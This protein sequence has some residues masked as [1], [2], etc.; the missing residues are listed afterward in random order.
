MPCVARVENARIR[1]LSIQHIFVKYEEFREYYNLHN[2]HYLLLL[3]EN[4]L[5]AQHSICILIY[6]YIIISTVQQIISH[7]INDL[8]IY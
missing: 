6:Y 4:L 5:F 2:L 3:G 8:C 1:F 7:L